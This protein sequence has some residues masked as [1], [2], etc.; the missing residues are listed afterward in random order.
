MPF[1][2]RFDHGNCPPE[3]VLLI[4]LHGAHFGKHQ[5]VPLNG[6]GSALWHLPFV[7]SRAVRQ[8]PSGLFKLLLM[9]QF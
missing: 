9:T 3:I 2:K 8:A 6:P 4:T 5:P 1:S 7:P